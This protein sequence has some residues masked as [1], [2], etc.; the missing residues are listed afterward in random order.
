[1]NTIT[2]GDDGCVFGT[3]S[4][5]ITYHRIG[6][7]ETD[8]DGSGWQ[9]VGGVLESSATWKHSYWGVTSEG[10]IYYRTGMSDA[11]DDGDGWMK[12]P[13]YLRRVA[14]GEV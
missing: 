6:I 11:D 9:S 5:G 4:S 7:S 3:T 1:L 2:V 12:V 13:G 10:N 8:L 14:V